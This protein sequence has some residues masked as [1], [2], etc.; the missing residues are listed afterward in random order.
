[1]LS[2][3]KYELTYHVYVGYSVQIIDILKDQI[4]KLCCSLL[5]EKQQQ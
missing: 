3:S 2:S 1:M 5:H 4:Y